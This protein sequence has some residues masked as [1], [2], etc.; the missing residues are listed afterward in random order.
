MCNCIG[1]MDDASSC[2]CPVH[3]GL[4]FIVFHTTGAVVGMMFA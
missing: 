3:K 2:T 1:A 4:P